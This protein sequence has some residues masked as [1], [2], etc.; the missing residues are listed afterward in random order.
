MHDAQKIIGRETFQLKFPTIDTQNPIF[1]KMSDK[2]SWIDSM[3]ALVALR[4]TGTIGNVVEYL[5]K[6]KKPRLS[7][8]IEQIEK[9]Y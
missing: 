4:K 9:H 7:P 5:Q 1:H 6:S 2:K 3:E 8:K